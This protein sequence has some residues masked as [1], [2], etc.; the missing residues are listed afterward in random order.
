MHHMFRHINL[1]VA[2]RQRVNGSLWIL[3]LGHN[4]EYRCRNSCLEILVGANFD[5]RCILAALYGTKDMETDMLDI[6]A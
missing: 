4:A 1:K 2:S 3:E 5:S 6:L